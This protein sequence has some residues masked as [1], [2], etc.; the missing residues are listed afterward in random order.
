MNAFFEIIFNEFISKLEAMSKLHRPYNYVKN[1]DTQ[2]VKREA[3]R[4][5]KKNH[6]SIEHI[7]HRQSNIQLVKRVK[8]YNSF[9]SWP[10]DEKK[11]TTQ[12][13]NKQNG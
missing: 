4:R 13:D 7:E 11:K 10:H 12:N 3:P 9:D 2:V 1:T 6:D 5:K 8:L